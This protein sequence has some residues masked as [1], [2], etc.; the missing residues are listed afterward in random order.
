MFRAVLF[1]IGV[2]IMMFIL[3]HVI[4]D[5][6]L[7]YALIFTCIAGVFC[8]LGEIIGKLD[9]IQDLLEKKC[10]SSRERVDNDHDYG[11]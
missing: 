10:C 3:S 2:F 6:N 11:D 4:D 9:S 1:F 7:K 5:F 8:F